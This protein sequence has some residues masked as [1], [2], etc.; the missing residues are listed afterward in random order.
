MAREKAI[1]DMSRT[2]K[3]QLIATKNPEWNFMIP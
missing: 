3:E 1:K 2:K